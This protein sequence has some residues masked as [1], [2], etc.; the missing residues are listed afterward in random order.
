MPPKTVSGISASLVQG[1]T[2]PHQKL[3]RLPAAEIEEIIADAVRRH[4]GTQEASSD[5]QEV[6][7]SN[8]K[9]VDVKPGLLVVQ[10]LVPRAPDNQSGLLTENDMMLPDP[11]SKAS[12]QLGAGTPLTL[13][14]S[15]TKTPSK[16]P[17]ELIPPSSTSSRSDLRPI[18]LETRTKLIGAIAKGR[19]WLD[20]LLAGVVTN[21][22]QIAARESC[23]VR[24]VNMTISLAFLGPDLVNAAIEGGLP[25][26]VGVANLRDAPLLWSEQSAMLG[27]AP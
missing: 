16:K 1:G 4:M 14:V 25:R 17:R 23:S 19:R 13:E 24:Q 2:G 8:V 11:K 6:I 12:G 7:S 27:L 26:G 21:P 18:R 3:D 5:D 9:R 20:E 15:W 10:L 22:D